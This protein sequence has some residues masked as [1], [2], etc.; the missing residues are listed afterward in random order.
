MLLAL[1]CCVNENKTN[2]LTKPTSALVVCFT[3][4]IVI[5]LFLK[6]DVAILIQYE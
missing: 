3:R 5:K 6:S 1:F 2:E 4:L